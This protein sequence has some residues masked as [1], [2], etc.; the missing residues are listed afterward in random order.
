MATTISGL[1]V[2]VRGLG[3]VVHRAAAGDQRVRRLEEEERRL[4][5]VAAHFLLVLYVVAADAENAP[6]RKPL[7][8]VLDRERRNFPNRNHMRHAF[9]PGRSG[10]LIAPRAP[11]EPKSS[12]PC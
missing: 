10:I 4:A 9:A 8:R 3:R 7:L 11:N 1:I 12:A 5:P 6:H 2:V